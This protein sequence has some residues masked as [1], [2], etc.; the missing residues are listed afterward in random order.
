VNRLLWG[1]ARRDVQ[2]NRKRLEEAA[3]LSCRL[4]AL[5]IADGEIKKLII[6]LCYE[7]DAYIA[8]SRETAEAFY[9]PLVLDALDTAGAAVNVFLKTGNEAAVE[10]YFSAGFA[11]GGDPMNRE[12]IL[13]IL[14]DSVRALRDQNGVLAAGDPEA[15]VAAL[16][17][18]PKGNLRASRPVAE[19]GNT[20]PNGES[21]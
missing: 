14:R 20:S 1:K 4:G 6:R 9:E 21:G 8:K 3:A 19:P 16:A 13:E 11:D 12:R 18:E 2:K 17:A 7:A 10:K 5:R 15:A